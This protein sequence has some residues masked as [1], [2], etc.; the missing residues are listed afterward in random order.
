MRGR[1]HPSILRIP[2]EI[3]ENIIS[4]VSA[5][6]VKEI[7]TLPQFYY[8]SPLGA[9]EKRS[10]G[11][12][13]GW[14]RIH[15]LSYPWGKSVNDDIRKEYGSLIYQT[16]DDAIHLIQRHGHRCILRKHDLKDAFRMIPVSPLDY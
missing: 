12:F 1:N 13:N 2:T 5:G 14:R 7:V 11:A 15:D 16:L 3:T 6:R 10:N 9:V 8:I 4:E